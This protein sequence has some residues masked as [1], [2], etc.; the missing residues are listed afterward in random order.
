[1]GTIVK[2]IGGKGKGSWVT[3][4]DLLCH[5]LIHDWGVMD[6]RSRG[7]QTSLKC[8]KY[9]LTARAMVHTLCENSG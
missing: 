3:L 7:L 6:S 8:L 2:G 9:Q 5:L 1:M 4:V